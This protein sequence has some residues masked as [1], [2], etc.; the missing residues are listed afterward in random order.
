MKF[1]LLIV[2]VG[3]CFFLEDGGEVMNTIDRVLGINADPVAD[4]VILCVLIYYFEWLFKSFFDFKQNIRMESK[5]KLFPQTTRHQ[6]S[7]LLI[8]TTHLPIMLLLERDLGITILYFSYDNN[9]TFIYI[10]IP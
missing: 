10:I 9:A 5:C 4:E 3:H 6:F 1:C 2:C 7:G 8:P